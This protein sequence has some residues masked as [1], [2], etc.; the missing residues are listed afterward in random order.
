MRRMVKSVNYGTC[1]K[2]NCRVWLEYATFTNN[3]RKKW[4]QENLKDI[5]ITL[6]KV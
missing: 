5:N 1:Q 3:E 4:G 6:E 2:A